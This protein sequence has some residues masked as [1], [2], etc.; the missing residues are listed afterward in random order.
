MPNGVL[1]DLY[2]DAQEVHWRFETKGALEVTVEL[3]F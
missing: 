2:K 3:H 1:Q